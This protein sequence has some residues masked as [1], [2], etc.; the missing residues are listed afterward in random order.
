ME[1][2]RLSGLRY[3]DLVFGVMDSI[4]NAVSDHC[5]PKIIPDLSIRNIDGKCLIVLNVFPGTMRPYYLR[6]KGILR[7]TYIRIGSTTRP[8]EPYMVKDLILEGENRYFDKEICRELIVNEEDI[9]QLCAQMKEVALRN[10]WN[11]HEK[12]Q[13]RPLTRN[14]L[15]SWGILKEEGDQ[16]VAT[17]AF[18]LLTG[19]LPEQPVIQCAVF[20]GNTRA[21]FIDRREFAGSIQEQIEAAYQ[22]VLL[23]INVGMKVNGIYREDVYELPTQSIRE[24]IANAVVHRSYNDPG[25]I[26]IAL[27]DDRL[28]VTSPG[29]LLNGISIQKMKEG[30]TKLR[31]PA[32]AEACAYMK[33]IEKWG[34]GIPRL[35]QECKEY[36]LPEP[37]LI[38]FEGDFRVNMYRNNPLLMGREQYIDPTQVNGNPTQASGNPTQASGNSTQASGNSTQDS[39]N[40]TQANG[41]R[42]LNAGETAVLNILRDNPS[43]SQKRIAE[44]LNWKVDR[45]KYYLNTLKRKKAVERVGS[46][47]KGFWKINERAEEGEKD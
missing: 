32:I 46:S 21:Y 27:Y 28:E 17:N 41:K 13:I 18:G 20:K 39:G 36:G 14:H 12:A 7:G 11:E 43:L 38:D 2:L 45:V 5:E 37:E 4:A 44:R 47:Q 3:P 1:H 25:K 9:N 42:Q 23:K 15:L 10:T 26:Q 35:F 24:L 6:S 29:M 31:N 22:Y 40:P 16:I 8:A 33:I 34:S 30:Y 19:R